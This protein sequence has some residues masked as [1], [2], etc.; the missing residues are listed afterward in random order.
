MFAPERLRTY[1]AVTRQSYE[2][3]GAKHQS[4]G[5][6][7]HHGKRYH[8]GNRLRKLRGVN[9]R[10]P[11]RPRREA[12]CRPISA[13]R[14]RANPRKAGT[15]AKRRRSVPASQKISPV[16]STGADQVRNNAECFVAKRGAQHELEAAVAAAVSHGQRVDARRCPNPSPQDARVATSRS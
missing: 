14:R 10:P 8:H 16:T 12:S 5:D 2:D 6:S 9:A 7:M 13:C 1:Q 15:P 4:A 11:G 3:R